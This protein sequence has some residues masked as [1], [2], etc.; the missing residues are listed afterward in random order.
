MRSSGRSGTVRGRPAGRSCGA[1]R[2]RGWP[3]R[4]RRAR[5]SAM[6]SAPSP[7]SATTVRSGS[8]SRMR[9]T[10]RR[11]SAWSSASRM[12]VGLRSSTCSRLAGVGHVAGVPRCRRRGPGA[13][14]EVGADEQGPFA[15]AAD[16]GAFRCAVRCR[17]RCRV[18]SRARHAAPGGGAEVDFDAVGAGVAGGVGQAF[19]GDA[20]ED[21]FGLRGRARA[22]R[23]RG[24]RVRARPCGGELGGQGPQ[25][26]EQAEFLQDAGA[27]PAGDAADLVQAGA[28]GLL[29]LVQV[30]AQ[31][32]AG[33]GRRRA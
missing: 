25:G 13:D 12:R 21:E 19:L 23:R 15:H 24:G 7:A 31:R 6:A 33:P 9:R 32:S 5:A 30:V 2:C 29:R 11:T 10:P 4:C 28:G 1:W 17:G 26:A 20:V 18:T 8:P 22:G 16:A 27:Q 14:G 3:G